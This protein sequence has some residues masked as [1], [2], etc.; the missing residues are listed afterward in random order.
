MEYNLGPNVSEE[1]KQK[2]LR[3]IANQEVRGVT[4]DGKTITIKREYGE[5][6]PLERVVPHPQLGVEKMKSSDEEVVR[7]VT[8]EL[9]REPATREEFVAVLTNVSRERGWVIEWDDE[10]PEPRA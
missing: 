6:A 1:E 5:R 8:L 10:E 2:I 4:E 3:K 9:G 7:I